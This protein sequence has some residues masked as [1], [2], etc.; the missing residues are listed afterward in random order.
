MEDSLGAGTQ[1]D[2]AP[3][4][5]DPHTKEKELATYPSV[6]PPVKRFPEW[7]SVWSVT[8]SPGL[9]QQDEEWG[10]A[11]THPEEHQGYSAANSF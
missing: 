7:P 5:A 3:W 4:S 10:R 9:G 11:A 8:P 2:P 1:A 6:L